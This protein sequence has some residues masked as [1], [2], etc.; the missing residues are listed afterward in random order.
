MVPGT[1]FRALLSLE[2]GV[3]AYWTVLGCMSF[4]GAMTALRPGK[5]LRKVVAEDGLLTVEP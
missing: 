2:H 5:E 3:C 4:G 1:T